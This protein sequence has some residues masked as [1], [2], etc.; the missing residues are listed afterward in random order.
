MLNGQTEAKRVE[1]RRFRENSV[2]INGAA[3]MGYL[4]R[5]W[6]SVAGNGAPSSIHFSGMPAVN[7]PSLP[8]PHLAEAYRMQAARWCP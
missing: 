5:E 8:K 2:A 3:A 4:E 7:V 6:V 1:T